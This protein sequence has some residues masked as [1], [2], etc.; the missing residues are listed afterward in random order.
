MPTQLPLQI[1]GVAPIVA[2]TPQEAS[3]ILT[4]RP[5]WIDLEISH[6]IPTEFFLKLVKTNKLHLS[7]LDSQKNDSTD[8]S[9]PTA[10]LAAPSGLNEQYYS[11]FPIRRDPHMHIEQQALARQLSYIHC[12]FKGH[13]ESAQMWKD[14][15]P[16]GTGVCIHSSTQRLR[17]SLSSGWPL[18]LIFQMHECPYTGPTVQVPEFFCNIASVRKD[19]SFKDQQEIRI[20]AEVDLTKGAAPLPGPD[21]KLVPVDLDILLSRIM[22]GP[23]MPPE[24]ERTIRVALIDAKLETVVVKSTIQSDD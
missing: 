20:L 13:V 4:R 17:K 24:E 16:N 2:S 14:F 5:E 6:Y 11:A 22:I 10:N 8:G 9:F 12:W 23:S 15:G 3:Q 7:R 19:I 18:D 1:V 21:Y